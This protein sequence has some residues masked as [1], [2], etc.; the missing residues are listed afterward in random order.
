MCPEDI[1]RGQLPSAHSFVSL[2]KPDGS[3]ELGRGDI[4]SHVNLKVFSKI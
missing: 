1:A 2:I 4:R 3:N